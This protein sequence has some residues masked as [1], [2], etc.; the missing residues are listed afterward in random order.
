MFRLDALAGSLLT[1]MKIYQTPSDFVIAS[2]PMINNPYNCHSLYT[3]LLPKKSLQ[4][5]RS[6]HLQLPF[7]QPAQRLLRRPH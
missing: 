5:S 1:L 4:G 6:R 2:V 7:Q 3:F